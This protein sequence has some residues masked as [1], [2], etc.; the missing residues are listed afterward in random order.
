MAAAPI[1]AVLHVD[2]IVRSDI[3]VERTHR[4]SMMRPDI[5]VRS[6]R[7]A[8][9]EDVGTAYLGTCGVVVPR[10]P[11]MAADH[12][13]LLAIDV[14]RIAAPTG[15]DGLGIDSTAVRHSDILRQPLQGNTSLAKMD[16]MDIAHPAVLYTVDID[17]D[18]AMV[19]RRI[20]T[21]LGNTGKI[22]HADFRY[23]TWK[24][25][26]EYA[27]IQVPAVQLHHDGII[28]YESI[29]RDRYDPALAGESIA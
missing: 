22:L 13:V 16:G 25:V 12:Q 17:C 3:V 7:S 6:L 14:E 18:P 4:P 21:I 2:L 26:A 5:T 19:F 24:P 1:A 29:T 28:Q 11:A 10:L 23:P 27:H 8:V 9:A 20:R 15:N